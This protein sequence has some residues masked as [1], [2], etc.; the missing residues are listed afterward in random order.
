MAKPA[1]TDAGGKAVASLTVEVG[2]RNPETG[3]VPVKLPKGLIRTSGSATPFGDML[4]EWQLRDF[5][6]GA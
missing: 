6:E 3:R 4:T 2:E 5:P 1:T